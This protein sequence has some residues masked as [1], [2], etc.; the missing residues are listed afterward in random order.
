MINSICCYH[1]TENMENHFY[2]SAL[3]FRSDT[4]EIWKIFIF[5][6][7]IIFGWT[8]NMNK[9]WDRWICKHFSRFFRIILQVLWDNL[10][11]ILHMN[12][13]C[14][15][16]KFFDYFLDFNLQWNVYFCRMTRW[17]WYAVCIQDDLD[18]TRL[19]PWFAAC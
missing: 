1:T 16:F 12:L 19:V 5:E 6:I 3:K 7:N 15:H 18:E 17:H 11:N 2:L 8:I 14:F 13:W 10:E 9:I 4:H